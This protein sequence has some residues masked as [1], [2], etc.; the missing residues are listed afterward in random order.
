[1]NLF[2]IDVEKLLFFDYVDVVKFEK[3]GYINKD[4][5]KE[6]FFGN[7]EEIDDELI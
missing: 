3:D 6:V 2:V 7:Y 5:Y 1:M 4:F